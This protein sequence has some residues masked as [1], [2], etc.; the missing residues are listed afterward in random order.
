[1][2]NTIRGQALV[3]MDACES[4]SAAAA[5]STF[6]DSI[7]PQSPIRDLQQNIVVLAASPW[8]TSTTAWGP[9]TL[10][11]RIASA[12]CSLLHNGRPLSV[13]AI[14]AH[15]SR[16]AI[17]NTMDHPLW[18]TSSETDDMIIPVDL[19]VQFR[20]YHR[21]LV[22]HESSRTLLAELEADSS[23]E[24]VWFLRFPFA[25]ERFTK[26]CGTAYWIPSDDNPMAAVQTIVQGWRTNNTRLRENVNVSLRYFG[27]VLDLE[28]PLM[29][30]LRE[31]KEANVSD[32]AMK[33]DR[34]YVV[35]IVIEDPHDTFGGLL[36]GCLKIKRCR[37]IEDDGYIY[38]SCGADGVNTK[39]LRRN[40]EEYEDEQPAPV[41]ERE[42]VIKRESNL[43][44]TTMQT[45]PAVGISSRPLAFSIKPEPTS[46]FAS[47]V[48]PALER[49][50]PV[51]QEP[52]W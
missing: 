26:S 42:P 31:I 34:V 13:V 3:I 27:H 21:Q 9:G 46:S 36:K 6:Q 8:S 50:R 38:N 2:E 25:V 17:W 32:G 14:Y 45:V 1:M 19:G 11:K 43:L 41:I 47:I 5:F 24:I 35:G 40:D 49:E 16:A 22:E 39:M 20:S 18:L 33:S 51:K 37:R 15:I 52:S 48:R 10:K 12:I 7:H 44:D 30:Q 28:A 29:E 4:G 23:K